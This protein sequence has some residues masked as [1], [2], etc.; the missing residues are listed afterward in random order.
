MCNQASVARL[1]KS[2]TTRLRIEGNW[3]SWRRSPR[4]RTRGAFWAE[5]VGLA[6]SF[7]EAVLGDQF[8][9]GMFEKSLFMKSRTRIDLDNDSITLGR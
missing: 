2:N 7:K 4:S 9:F 6:A 3:K 8:A 1:L 5:G